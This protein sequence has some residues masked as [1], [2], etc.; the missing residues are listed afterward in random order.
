MHWADRRASDAVPDSISDVRMAGIGAL[1]RWYR[2]ATRQILVRPGPCAE[3][4]LLPL[5]ALG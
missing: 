1:R 5:P 4:V 2:A 3:L